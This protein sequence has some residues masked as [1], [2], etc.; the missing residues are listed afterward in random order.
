MC[1][2]YEVVVDGSGFCAA[3]GNWATLGL[4]VNEHVERVRNFC[5]DSMG[6][7]T[8]TM[9]SSRHQPDRTNGHRRGSAGAVPTSLD[10]SERKSR[11]QRRRKLDNMGCITNAAPVGVGNCASEA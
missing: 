8:A 7:I 3:C 5:R 6:K 11:R 2:G 10:A 9:A 1:G 4:L